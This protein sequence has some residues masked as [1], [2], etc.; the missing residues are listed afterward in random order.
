[1]NT[2]QRLRLGPGLG[3]AQ[4]LGFYSQPLPRRHAWIWERSPRLWASCSL[5]GWGGSRSWEWGA[6]EHPPPPPREPQ[7]QASRR[8]RPEFP[9]LALKTLALT[10]P[11]RPVKRTPLLIPCFTKNH[12]EGSAVTEA[13][14]L[15]NRGGGTRTQAPRLRACACSHL[16]LLTRGL[17]QRL[18]LPLS[19][20]ALSEAPPARG[21]RPSGL[22][23]P[24]HGSIFK[25]DPERDQG[26]PPPLLPPSHG[27]LMLPPAG[28]RWCWGFSTGSH[29]GVL[30]G[31]SKHNPIWPGHLV[32]SPPHSRGSSHSGFLPCLQGA[33]PAP[34]PGPLHGCLCWTALSQMANFLLTLT[35][36]GK[37]PLLS[38]ACPDSLCRRASS[39]LSS[40]ATAPGTA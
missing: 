6:G 36:G 29:V 37:C 26:S 20:D 32:P 17:S 39:P 19:L 35:P 27:L 21:W 31:A 40:F 12:R 3:E 7:L 13:T 22:P 24:S 18:L 38:E 10:S 15:V 33:S 25:I 34:A 2:L 1:M 8:H 23:L 4:R 11:R 30:A 5:G 9:S 16:T 28:V 14:Q